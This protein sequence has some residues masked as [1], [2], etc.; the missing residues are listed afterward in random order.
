METSV[1]NSRK[2]KSTASSRSESKAESER[3]RRKRIKLFFKWNSVSFSGI[4][5]A[6]TERRTLKTAQ[7]KAISYKNFARNRERNES[8]ERKNGSRKTEGK[9][10]E[11]SRA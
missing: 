10:Q 11:A 3:D 2:R 7:E 4:A 8:R 5:K 1:R 6:R 9:T